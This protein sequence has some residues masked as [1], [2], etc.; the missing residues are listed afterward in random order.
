MRGVSVRGAGGLVI[1]VV[2]QPIL[3]VLDNPMATQGDGLVEAFRRVFW[4][5]DGYSPPADTS[6]FLVLRSLLVFA[7]LVLGVLALLGVR[8]VRFP[9]AAGCGVLALG[10]LAWVIWPFD[11]TRYRDLP[12]EWVLDHPL[13]FTGTRGTALVLL[14]M[15]VGA[16]V[17]A[18]TD[19]GRVAPTPPFPAGAWGPAGPDGPHGPRTPF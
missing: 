6:A 17:L 9:L 1:G 5:P 16:I 14:L 10:V 4:V 12:P 18:V 2:I 15:L 11:P 3:T 19:S 7:G 8:P 13:W